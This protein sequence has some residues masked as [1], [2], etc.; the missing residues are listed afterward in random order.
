MSMKELIEVSNRYGSDDEF[1]IAGG[2]NTSWKTDEYM[3]V[4]GSGTEL[5]TIGE[6]GFV[7]VDLKK[8]DLV[9][10]RTYSEDVDTRE[11][12][13]LADLMASRYGEEKEKRPSVETLLH[14]LLPYKFVV[15]THPALV[16]GMT[17]SR[18]GE[19]AVKELFGDLCI[20][21]PVTNPGYILAKEVKEAIESHM[22]KGKEFPLLIFLQNHGVFVSGNSIEEIDELYDSMFNK[23]KG[24]VNRFPSMEDLPVDETKASAL[25]EI[26]KKTLSEKIVI[27]PF[28]NKDIGLMSESEKSFSPLATSF[29]PDHIVYYGFKPVFA[30]D[31]A[32]LEQCITDYIKNY[33]V[34]PRL[35]VVSGIGAFAINS[36]ISMAEKSK[37]LFIDDVKIA[38]YAESFGGYQFMPED[39]INFI[40]N[41]EVEKYRVS[42]K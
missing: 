27:L 18:N 31:P 17:C 21:V 15:H 16:N 25:I 37:K 13:A 8:L 19:A 23:I 26:I 12:E 24:K 14:A 7:K 39:Q 40:R 29:T 3:Y 42:V 41:W 36:S 2:G 4:K 33:E 28:S 1:V 22:A 6:D 30:R 9:W 5:A 35:A 11:E 32:S 38:V 10:S 20:W 34:N